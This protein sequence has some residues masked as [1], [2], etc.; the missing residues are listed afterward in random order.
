VKRAMVWQDVERVHQFPTETK[1]KRDAGKLRLV[2]RYTLTCQ[3][4]VEQVIVVDLGA[5]PPPGA[6]RLS[7]KQ[8]ARE[9]SVAP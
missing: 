3:H 7:C 1:R 6:K 9:C 5:F 8:C 2:R 4:V